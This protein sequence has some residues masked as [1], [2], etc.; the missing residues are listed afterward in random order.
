MINGLAVSFA[1]ISVLS[2]IPT[3]ISPSPGGG[4]NA[5]QAVMVSF[6][7]AMS[8]MLAFAVQLALLLPLVGLA[9]GLFLRII[10]LWITTA[11]MPFSFLGYVLNGKLGTN[12]FEFE[13]D[14]W[15]EFINAAFLPMMVALP[16][17]IGFIMLSAVSQIPAPPGMFGLTMNV[18]ILAGVKTWWA[19]LWMLAAIGIIWSGTFKA[20]S[21]SKI[22]GNF[23]DKI[24]GFGE[25]VFGGLAQAPLLVPLPLPGGA[26]SGV[27]LGTLVHG[28]KIIAD[29][30]RLAASGTSGKGLG[31]ILG[32]RFGARPGGA[33]NPNLVTENLNKVAKENTENIVKAVQ[34]LNSGIS[35]ADRQAKFDEIRKNLNVNPGLSNGD[36]VKLLQQMTQVKNPNSEIKKFEVDI[37]KLTE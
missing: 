3:N 6:Q 14:I 31:D 21:K 35:G 16:I 24:K 1:R 12:V 27:N 37:K 32:D 26:K 18:P 29:S 22:I 8:V 13:T 25:S 19:L 5:K 2:K 23:T 30:V 17:V 28:P 34:A 15:K 20:L 36:T 11:F 10:I 9:V 4:L 7:V 33:D